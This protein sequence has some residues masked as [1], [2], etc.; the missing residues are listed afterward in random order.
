V[1]GFQTF[2]P[3]RISAFANNEAAARGVAAFREQGWAVDALTAN[4]I[5]RVEV[6]V[7]PV[8]HEV[9]LKALERWQRSPSASPKE[10]FLKTDV[11]A[12]VRKHDGR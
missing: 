2:D 3:G 5:L 10:A 12:R 4:A 7:P 11:A 6:H 8:V 1:A 9:P